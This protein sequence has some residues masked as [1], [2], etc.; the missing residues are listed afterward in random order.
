MS[1]ITQ[2]ANRLFE[3]KC[4]FEKALHDY[5]ND[6]TK[7]LNA[8]SDFIAALKRDGIIGYPVTPAKDARLYAV[9][10]GIVIELELEIDCNEC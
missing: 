4:V 6:Y 5:F 2:N 3:Y 1:L 8:Y 10:K 7:D 9:D